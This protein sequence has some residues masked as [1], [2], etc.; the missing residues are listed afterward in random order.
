MNVVKKTSGI[1]SNFS[2]Y[3]SKKKTQIKIAVVVVGAGAGAG[4]IC[5]EIPAL[6][7][8]FITIE[9]V[10]SIKSF[11]LLAKCCVRQNC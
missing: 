3:K 6:C 8:K 10:T 4:A 1:Q 11:L 7:G 5:T 2:T 9:C